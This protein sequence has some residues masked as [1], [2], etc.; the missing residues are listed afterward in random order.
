MERFYTH[1][2]ADL[3]IDEALRKAQ[4]EFITGKVSLKRGPFSG[5]GPDLSHPYYWAAFQLH[6]PGD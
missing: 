1:L 5:K 4:I 3:P 6:G 2:K